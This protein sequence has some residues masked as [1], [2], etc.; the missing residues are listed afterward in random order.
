MATERC[1]NQSVIIQHK[2]SRKHQ[3]ELNIPF[4]KKIKVEMNSERNQKNV[5][6]AFTCVSPT[7]YSLLKYFERKG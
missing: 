6:C 7:I 3:L 2:F 5:Y 1:L 4:D